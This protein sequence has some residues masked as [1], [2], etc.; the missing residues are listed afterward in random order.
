VREFTGF[1]S[2]IRRHYKVYRF[3]RKS[4]PF[5]C[6]YLILEDGFDFLNHI[7]CSTGYLALD[8]G[9]NDGTS[10]RMIRKFLPEVQIV[11]FDPVTK[12][13]FKLVNVEFQD[14]AL[15]SAFSTNQIY[16]PIVRGHELTQYSS[17]YKEKVTDQLVHDLG[18][19]ESEVSY[20]QRDTNVVTLDSLNMTPF[21]IKI[22]V[23]G[24][25]R[26]VILGSLKTI[27]LHRPVILIEIQ[28]IQRFNEMQSV[29]ATIGY[30]PIKTSPSS[31][32]NS[33]DFSLNRIQ[34][35]DCTVNNYIWIPDS[36][37]DAWGFKRVRSSNAP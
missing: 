17:F 32:L 16:T 25:E 19:S 24:F 15:G 20:N 30:V 6:K 18:I 36:G 22:D 10:I 21:F 2:W 27:K 37:S 34:S 31:N 7:S 4:A 3:V 29:L 11:A 5:L 12:P 14:I 28:S 8:I 9:A 33:K 13:K 35:Y 1:E 26:E 23:E